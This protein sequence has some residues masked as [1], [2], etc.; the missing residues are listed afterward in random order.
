MAVTLTPKLGLT[1]ADKGDAVGTWVDLWNTDNLNTEARL[2]TTFAG[3]PNGNVEGFYVGQQ[4]Y[5]TGSKKIFICTTVGIPAVAVWED[6]IAIHGLDFYS[7]A[8]SGTIL[9][10]D[11]PVAA[12]PSGWALITGVENKVLGLTELDAVI[13]TT[14]GS[15]SVTPVSQAAGDHNHGGTTGGHAITIS[16]MASHFH[17]VTTFK[18]DTASAGA[19]GSTLFNTE[20]KNTSS[21]GGNSPHDHPISASGTHVHIM[22]A[23]NN[24]PATI[25]FMLIK[26]T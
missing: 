3:D 26:K 9:V 19:G 17:T 10:W 20:S 22:D 21:V 5:D 23:F 8:P 14:V 18:N 1:Q 4:C 24:R 15:N 12:I 16:E 11:Q 6:Y 13:G 2:A 7:L 25:N